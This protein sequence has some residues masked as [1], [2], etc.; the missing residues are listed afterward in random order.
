M[1]H[2]LY[3]TYNPQVGE[4]FE[5]KLSLTSTDSPYRIKIII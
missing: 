1:I 2:T 3:L 5:N 4:R